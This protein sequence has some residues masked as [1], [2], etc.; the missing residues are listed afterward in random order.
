MPETTFGLVPPSQAFAVIR[1]L[2]RDLTDP[3]DCWF[4]HHGYCQA[5]MWL[6]EGE[7][8]HTRAKRF[9]ALVED[10]TTAP[11]GTTVNPSDGKAQGRFNNI[12][13]KL[14]TFEL[15]EGRGEILLSADIG[16][17]L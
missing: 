9:L 6:N 16:D 15:I 8:P 11:I 14:R 1:E 7:C 3:D 13:S 2:I 10:E 17:D 4:D 12:L 5:H